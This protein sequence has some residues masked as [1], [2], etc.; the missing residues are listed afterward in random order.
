MLD[1]NVSALVIFAAAALV[2]PLLFFVPAP[3]GRHA[4]AGW[5]PM[6]PAK[7]AWVAMEAV[8][9]VAFLGAWMWNPSR[10]EWQVALLAGLYLVHYAWRSFGFP[11]VMRG[12][13]KPHSVLTVLIAVVFNVLNGWGNGAALAPSGPTLPFWLGVAVMLAGA[14]INQHADAVLRGLRGEG[15]SG[16]K[17]PHGG[18]YRWVSAPNYLGEIV[19]WLGFAIAAGTLPAWAFFAFTVANLAPRAWSHHRWYRKT[20]P[21][22]PAQRRALVPYLF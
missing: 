13:G 21:E 11:L 2:L 5:G 1:P 16:Y 3:Y 18:L 10:F 17:V 20:F 12:P 9:L 14:A 8:S 7:V 4:R 6:L 19:E 22:Y 15:E